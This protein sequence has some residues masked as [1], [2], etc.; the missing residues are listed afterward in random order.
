M[1]KE[2]G[3]RRVKG[4]RTKDQSNEVCCEMGQPRRK[5][6]ISAEDGGPFGQARGGGRGEA[7]GDGQRKGRGG[8]TGGAR[9][10]RELGP[11]TGGALGGM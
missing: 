1:P 9:A 3:G 6:I 2:G 5:G 7:T 10:R 4:K 11:G 8:N